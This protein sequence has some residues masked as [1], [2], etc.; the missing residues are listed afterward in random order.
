VNTALK[1]SPERLDGARIIEVIRVEFV[2]G[3][4]TTDELLRTCY[5]YYDPSGGLLAEF[6]P[7]PDGKMPDEPD[8]A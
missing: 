5:R 8:S 2:R 6:D 7:C 4:G 1:R 3:G